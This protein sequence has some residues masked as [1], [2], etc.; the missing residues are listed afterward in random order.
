[1]EL[2]GAIYL[3]AAAFVSGLLGF[4]CRSLIG[5]L[6][7]T[8]TWIHGAIFASAFLCY[9]VGG[10][11]SKDQWIQWLPHLAS[12][13]LTAS[14]GAALLVVMLARFLV[15]INSP[16]I[17][18]LEI[19]QTLTTCSA[20]LALAYGGSRWRRSELI[21]IAYATLVFVA[22]KLLFEDLRH[23]HLV[24]IAASFFLYAATLILLPRLA[25]SDHTEQTLEVIDS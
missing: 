24:F 7:T 2:H 3:V 10:R 9:L 5:S 17:G 21:W 4:A 8:P 23:D 14:A 25:G 19:I 18:P 13:T 1:L 20:A 12:A 11:F 6:P 22:A 16:N 15:R